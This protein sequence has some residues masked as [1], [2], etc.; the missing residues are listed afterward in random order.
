M[1]LRP[2]QL[3]AIDAVR[4]AYRAGARAVVLQMATGAGKTATA[5]EPLR[6]AVA[7]GHRVVFLAHLDAILDDT[8]ERLR[9]EGLQV[10]LLQADRPG[11]PA[12][13]VQVASLA[14]LHARG[15][16]P[17][18]DL[19][20]IDE[21]HR[22]ASPGVRQTLAAYPRAR[23][24]GLTATPQRGDGQALGDIFQA[25]VCGPSLA[26]LTAQ[27]YLVP[28]TIH[29]PVSPVE[30][31][32]G[33]DPV[34]AYQRWCGGR[35]TLVFAANADH[36]RELAAGLTAAGAP[37]VTVLDET[38]RRARAAAREGLAGG[39]LAAVVTV[40]AL[41]EG[42]DCPAVAAVIL[43]QTFG[44]VS[45]YLQALGRGLRPAPG[46]R[47]LV[48]CDLRGAVYLHGRP[49]DERRWTLDGSGCTGPADGPGLRRCR[50]CHAVFPAAARCPLC[51]SRSLVDPR[52][53]RVQR[54][55]F[56][57]AS[58]IPAGER[59][60]MYLERVVAAMTRSGRMQE[61][62]ARRLALRKA[63]E[64]VRL[65]AGGGQAA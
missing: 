13:P 6:L 54:A 60:R 55:E 42:W 61:S 41:L 32:L 1:I 20:V 34:E 56:W 35:P 48:V 22:A 9:A 11:D 8:A 53:V 65:A 12:A 3:Q 24:L 38:N 4:A 33:M 45:G 19:V 46:K 14:T 36:A 31:A 43:C 30:G 52:P 63:P 2:Y 25:L 40:R 50:D 17:P 62:T 5:A 59:A 47:D 58:S 39:A 29:A 64:W 51:G 23:I 37:A 15:E 21:C 26:D 27:G 16:Y 10:G 44:T 7:R 18:A 49:T 28:A 57:Q